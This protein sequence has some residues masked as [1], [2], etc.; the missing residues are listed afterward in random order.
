MT[1]K[2]GKHPR[3]SAMDYCSSYLN[4]PA[5]GLLVFLLAGG[6]ALFSFAAPFGLIRL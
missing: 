6:A 2:R 3:F 1:E 5:Y 4:C